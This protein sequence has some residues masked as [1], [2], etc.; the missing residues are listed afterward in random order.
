MEHLERFL[1]GQRYPK[2]GRDLPSGR[3]QLLEG[4]FC[5]QSAGDSVQPAQQHS[6]RTQRWHLSAIKLLEQNLA[7]SYH[8]KCSSWTRLLSVFAE[9]P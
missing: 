1:E 9:G 3:T 4:T 6:T 8:H 2:L 7:R 5:P